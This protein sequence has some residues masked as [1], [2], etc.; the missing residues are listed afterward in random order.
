MGLI[1]VYIGFGNYGIC[2][3]KDK[4][5]GTNGPS[6]ITLARIEEFKFE[7]LSQEVEKR[8]VQ[9]LLRNKA[10]VSDRLGPP[11]YFTWTQIFNRDRYVIHDE[12]NSAGRGSMFRLIQNSARETAVAVL[13]IEDWKFTRNFLEG[14]I[15]NTAEET[16][17][18][19]ATYSDVQVNWTEQISA[20]KLV[21]GFKILRTDPYAYIGSTIGHWGGKDNLPIAIVEAR[22][23]Y[24]LFN[25]D[26]VEGRVVFPITQHLQLATGVN[27]V[28]IHLIARD[29]GQTSMSARLEYV[30]KKQNG[31]SNNRIYIGAYKGSRYSVIAAG[32]IF[33]W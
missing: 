27:A 7:L 21:Y 25:S 12:V 19:N 13:P 2:Q 24:K 10:V 29:E 26:R 18:I 15:G 20:A 30:C 32:F 17:T 9:E 5:K 23:G 14:S 31:Y 4:G 1:G 28:P 22:L 16:P 6:R 33:D 3:E 8:F 11:S